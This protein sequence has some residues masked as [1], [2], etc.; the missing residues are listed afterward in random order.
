[1]RTMNRGK[2]LV[3]ILMVTCALAW[4]IQNAAAEDFTPLLRVSASDLYLTAGEENRI[5][6]TLQNMGN[7]NVYEVKA[8]L[9]VPETT[10]G[11]TILDG[12]HR[13]YNKIEDEK[14][15]TYHPVLYVDR[16]TPLG[17]YTLSFQVSYLKAFRLGAVR[18]ELT[19]VQI[20][21]WWRTSPYPSWGSTSAWR[22]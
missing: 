19:T 13:I 9:S 12:A 16:T 15:K 22:R 1:M 11:I 14:S 3:I 17:S 18:E 5:E 7:Y 2:T 8:T 10:T 20:G 4:Q 6:I 21:V